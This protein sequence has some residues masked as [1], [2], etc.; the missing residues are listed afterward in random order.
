VH[1]NKHALH[2]P[3]VSVLTDEKGGLLD[4]DKIRQ[5]DLHTDSSVTI[6][7]GLPFD[8]LKDVG[9]MLGF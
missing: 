8:F 1:A 4:K 2:L 9:V 6:T 3:M 5:I 7:K